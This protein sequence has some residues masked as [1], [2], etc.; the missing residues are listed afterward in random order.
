[1][2]P[3]VQVL[4]DLAK[5]LIGKL[6]DL[7]TRLLRHD[8]AN[9][10]FD[11]LS[12]RSSR[13]SSMAKE[14]ELTYHK[15]VSTT[16]A[17]H[18]R[19][20]WEARWNAS[21]EKLEQGIH[22]LDINAP[23]DKLLDGRCSSTDSAEQIFRELIQTD[24]ASTNFAFRNLSK[25]YEGLYQAEGTL[26]KLQQKHGE[27]RRLMSKYEAQLGKMRGYGEHM[28]SRARKLSHPNQL[29][30]RARKIS[31]PSRKSSNLGA[32]GDHLMA[33]RS[34]VV[35]SRSSSTRSKPS[36]SSRSGPKS[37][38]QMYIPDPANV[39]DV[40]LGRIINESPYRICVKAVPGEVGR[41][42]FGE[43]QPKLAYCRI[44]KSSM[45]MVRVGG[46]W[47]ELTQFLRDHALLEEDFVPRERSFTEDE[48][49]REGFVR[50]HRSNAPLGRVI[51]THTSERG[52]KNGDRF[53]VGNGIE[54]KMKRAQD[55]RT[56]PR[57]SRANLLQN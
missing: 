22:Q 30:M 15:L 46:G 37:A 36:M 51:K 49:L 29:E 8:A 55:E 41:Y 16:L 17:M 11:A 18:L 40:E 6:D 7:A 45:V 10:S 32:F 31:L 27:L 54:V 2:Q 12:V 25:A 24:I 44:L 26:L 5:D 21:K 38:R 14:L 13:V 52:I 33:S 57:S 4:S 35:S 42:W 48:G 50:T 34:A 39:L 3:E 47:T 9:G 43:S 20:I 1:V 28:N 23:S 19:Q 53:I 56:V